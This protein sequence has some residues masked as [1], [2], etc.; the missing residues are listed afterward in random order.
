MPNTALGIFNKQ[1]LEGQGLALDDELAKVNKEIYERNVELAIKNRTLQ[2]IRQMYEIMNSTYDAEE[3]ARKLIATIVSELKLPKGYI[4]LVDK[5]NNLIRFV[6][7]FPAPAAGDEIFAIEDGKLIIS[8]SESDNFCVEAILQNRRR[9]TNSL[10]DLFVPMLSEIRAANYQKKLGVETSII[11]P[12]AFS[13]EVFGV[14]VLALDKHLGFLSSAEKD[15]L[16]E[17]TNVVAVAI[18]RAQI[19]SD[20]QSA[21][22]RLEALDQ[23][24]DEFISIAS[25]EL[26]T[27]MTAIKSYVWMVLNRHA[28]T[29][30]PKTH[31]YLDRVY[32]S[33]ERLINLVNEML[34]VSRIESGRVML[35]PAEFDLVELAQ[36]IKREVQAKLVEKNQT[37][38]V[39]NT[40]PKIP[41]YADREKVQQVFENLVGNSIKYSPVD[42]RISIEM[43]IEK[44]M[45]KATV[46]DNGKGISP[47]DMPKLFKKFS[48]LES[49]MAALPEGGT[50]LGLY[51]S[52][53]FVELSGGKIWAESELGQVTRFIFT[54]PLYQSLEAKAV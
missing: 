35:K 15:A 40:Q 9:M 13:S 30:T 39:E 41:V 42:G 38:T 19:Y 25:H 7:E 5:K 24:K 47:E 31:E 52:R 28:D 10:Y 45:A 21:N 16:K 43:T 37:L 34:N 27:P 18:E 32:K 46:A 2:L 53:Q 29:L 22:I 8:L 4:I 23:L 6:S 11:Y 44:S 36:D 14:M 50:G 1:H 12:L 54:L 17:I 3:T 33:T 20:L 51:I 48:R 49:S 26:R